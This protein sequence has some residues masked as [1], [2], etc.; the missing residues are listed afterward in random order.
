MACF[1]ILASFLRGDLSPGLRVFFQKVFSNFFLLL[2]V[3]L[4]LSFSSDF[5]NNV[6]TGKWH[7]LTKTH[8]S[9]WGCA[10]LFQKVNRGVCEFIWYQ[11]RQ[12]TRRATRRAS[13]PPGLLVFRAWFW[14]KC[15]YVRFFQKVNRG[16][17]GCRGGHRPNPALLFF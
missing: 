4:K 13:Q 7:V 8:P 6:S 15:K 10:I 16:L 11:G 3:V 17:V 12:P 2:F 9:V 14:K 5:E 1:H